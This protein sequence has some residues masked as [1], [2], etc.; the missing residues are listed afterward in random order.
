M[1][2]KS[3]SFFLAILFGFIATGH[4]QQSDQFGLRSAGLSIGFYN[5]ELDYWKNDSE[6]RDADF[7]GAFNAAASVEL[8]LIPNL[9]ARAGL[10]IWQTSVDDDL[11]G[12]GETTW[13]LTGIPINADLI[14]FVPPLRFANVS[15]YVGAGGEFVL[16]QQK[17]RFDQKDDP[18][19]VN[20]TTGLFNGIAGLEFNFSAQFSLDLELQYK[21]GSYNQDF[22]ILS[23]NPDDPENPIDKTITE[24]ISLS[25]IMFGVRLKYRF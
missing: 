14:Y 13:S 6:F 17:L 24:E 12:F 19:P 15:P 9:I 21:L 10:G 4:T 7:K 5:P 8:N 3:V 20:G 23:P 2:C 11:T 25:G 1:N 22:H 18:D 16:L